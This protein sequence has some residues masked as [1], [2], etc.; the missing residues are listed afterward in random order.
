MARTVRGR[1]GAAKKAASRK[2][3]PK[4]KA[5]A[6]V[7]KKAAARNPEDI[8]REEGRSGKSCPGDEEGRAKESRHARLR[9]E[10]RRSRAGRAPSTHTAKPRGGAATAQGR[11]AAG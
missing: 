8:S 7:K 9:Q 1:K 2:A 10:I 4:A 6:A 5:K 11:G 3:A